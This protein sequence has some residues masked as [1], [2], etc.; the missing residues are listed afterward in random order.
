MTATV[1]DG[2]LT[3]DTNGKLV[4][5]A[6]AL[7]HGA[8]QTT[9]SLTKSGAGTLTLT[10]ANTYTGATLISGG[11]LQVG[12]STTGSIG[13]GSA[14]T[15]DGSTAVLAGTGTVNGSTTLTTGSI[16]PGDSG[17]ASIGTLTLASLTTGS[18][19]FL[20]LDIAAPGS[21]DRLHVIGSLSVD[22]NTKITVGT[23]A[24]FT[25]VVGNSWDLLDWAGAFGGTYLATQG[26]NLI[27]PTLS[28]GHTWDSTQFTNTG[29]ISI[30]GVPE[31]SRAV[32]LLFGA[33]GLLMR[34]RRGKEKADS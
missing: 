10:G 28:G 29:V 2:G 26:T 17:G 9:D 24:G 30:S 18:G 33:A 7:L 25:D 15:V 34:R 23:Q 20:N 31:P 16:N 5:I 8:A 32:L 6:Q 14:L 21:S 19:T 12:L 11:T 22:N 1:N 3:F 27:L 4:T 13:A